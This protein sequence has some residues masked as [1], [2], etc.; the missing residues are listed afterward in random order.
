ML[1][2]ADNEDGG[3]EFDKLFESILC[4]CTDQQQ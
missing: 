3:G 4:K 1:D 2:E